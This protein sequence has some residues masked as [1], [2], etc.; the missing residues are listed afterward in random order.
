[1]FVLWQETDIESRLSRDQND[2]YFLTITVVDWVDLFNR[3]DYS[4]IVV[5]SLKYCIEN[6]G[7]VSALP[8]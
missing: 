1:M 7:L 5:D 8:R 4:I 2:N 6:K 3:K